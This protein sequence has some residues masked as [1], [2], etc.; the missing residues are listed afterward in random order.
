MKPLERSAAIAKAL[1]SESHGLPQDFASRVAELAAASA[2]PRMSWHE[3]AILGAFL[4]MI[5]VCLAGWFWLGGKEPLGPEW[6]GP[7][8]DVAMSQPWLLIGVAGIAIV[9]MLSFRRR[10]A[11]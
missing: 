10:A 3:G 6:L 5:A 9:Q 2:R 1:A 4:V 7:I 8:V 11:I